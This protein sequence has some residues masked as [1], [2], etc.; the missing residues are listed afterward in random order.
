MDA[1]L[2]LPS[3][4][5]HLFCLND[6]QRYIVRRLLD[7]AHREEYYA[8]EWW[9]DGT[10]STPSAAWLDD[11]FENVDS[12]EDEGMSTLTYEEGDVVVM[13][14]P[15]T[16]GTITLD[17]NAKTLHW[18]KIGKAV[19]VSGRL[20][21]SS[22]SSPVGILRLE[23]LPWTV[24]TGNQ[25]YSA[26][27]IYGDRLLGTATTALHALAMQGS[28]TAII[29]RFVAGGYSPLADSVQ[30]TSIFVLGGWFCALT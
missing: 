6:G 21:V 26:L 16:S 11:I 1:G 20:A 2:A 4:G 10:Y 8:S 5:Q 29:H 18:V 13:M 22:V 14:V 28:N 23:G 24:A 17:P 25:F 12:L 3:T 15:L 30:A 9:P 27:A 19:F 7:L